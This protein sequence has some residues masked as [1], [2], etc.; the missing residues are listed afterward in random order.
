M[1]CFTVTFT[2]SVLDRLTEHSEHYTPMELACLE[3]GEPQF[4]LKAPTAALA[5]TFCR[6]TAGNDD[7]TCLALDTPAVDGTGDE[8]DSGID[9]VLDYDGMPVKY[10]DTPVLT[11]LCNAVPPLTEHARFAREFTEMLAAAG[12]GDVQID[13]ALSLLDGRVDPEHTRA[14]QQMHG[15]D[16][17][18]QAL[19]QEALNEVLWL[20]GVSRDPK[21]DFVWLETRG[22][23]S[24]TL[25]WHKDQLLCGPA[26]ELLARIT[27]WHQNVLELQADADSLLGQVLLKRKLSLPGKLTPAPVCLE[28]WQLYQQE[29]ILDALDTNLEALLAHAI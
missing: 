7:F 27:D 24:A 16:A 8:L 23:Y 13:A 26:D 21:H 29:Q 15:P 6:L 5:E 12:F 17:D 10:R 19:L 3:T 2:R 9:I 14:G 1:P 25:C 20:H 18:R 28:A 4:W 11:A 22:Q